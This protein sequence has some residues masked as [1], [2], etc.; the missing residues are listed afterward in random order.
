MTR[1]E[2]VPTSGPWWGTEAHRRYLLQDAARQ[3]RF[4]GESLDPAG[5][6]HAQDVTGAPIPGAPR[7]LHATT[8]MVHS[9]ALAHLLGIRGADRMV[10]HGMRAL[11][12]LHRDRTH[13]GYMWSFAPGGMVA[14]GQKLA[15]GHAFVLLAAASA[16][17][18]GHP[19][20]DRLLADICEVI[21]ARFW[22]H[23]NAR[24]TEEYARDWRRISDYRG[25]NANMH[26]SEA[27]LAA[28]EATGDQAFLRRA[29]G[30][31]D[32]FIGR[33]GAA[34]DWRLPEHYTEGW[35]IDPA[36]E[37]NP[38]FRPRGTTPGHSFELARLLL[39]AW[40]LDGRRDATLP[41]WAGRLYQRALAD[42]WDKARGGILYTVDLDGQPLRRDRYWW[43]VTE[44]IGASAALLKAGE[45]VAGDYL[46]FWQAA[47][48]LF[49]DAR[50]GG[51]I[52]E[53]DEDDRP[54]GRQFA[55]KPDIYHSIQAALL[56]LLPGL[57]GA[58][59]ELRAMRA[60]GLPDLFDPQLK[61]ARETPN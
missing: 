48:R 14:D 45:D 21:E 39:Q 16:K 37:G 18:A 59:D 60:S 15:Y 51:W 27:L 49:I 7:E 9:F 23:D 32:F 47:E 38:M 11:W 46:M 40:D 12:E 54:L 25:M 41:D 17:Q 57:S 28:A 58:A 43:P 8:R 2:Q 53:I 4:F 52:P 34:H 42:G 13:G 19:D 56:P 44:A 31:F 6:F 29:R 1:P 3:F 36:Y 22:D 20:A 30:I 10:D 55:G 5:G 61:S 26:M 24:M 35:R 33:I 50:H